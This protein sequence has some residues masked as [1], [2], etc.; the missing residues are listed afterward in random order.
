VVVFA[1]PQLSSLVAYVRV[2]QRR[3]DDGRPGAGGLKA[4][5]AGADLRLA[6]PPGTLIEDALSGEVVSDLLRPGEEAVVAR[7]G[8]GGRGNVHFK[9]SVRRSP[10]VAEPG[11]AGE[12]R[13]LRLELKLIADAGLVGA[14]NAGKS[15]LLRALSNATPKV[16]DYP[17]TT[18][19]PELG[20]VETGRG[21]RLTMADVPGLIPG[22][23]S[24]AG[25][26]L[27][28]LRHLERTRVLVL[29]LDGAAEDPFAQLESIRTEIAAYSPELAARPHLVAVNKLDLD[30]VRILR[31]SRPR[32]G[33]LWCSAHSGEGLEELVEAIVAALARAPIPDPVP[34]PRVLRLRPKRGSQEPVEVSRRGSGFALTGDRL[35]RLV[36][37]TDFNSP[38]SLQRFQVQ[39]DRIG[40]STL[41][42][43]AGAQP[44]D[45]VSACGMEFE[46]RP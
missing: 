23:A 45:M 18:L 4:G 17:F 11:R 29:L 37:V 3:A 31:S 46:Y 7:G 38:A 19:D 42:E 25:L 44:G 40:V 13:E 1:D 24:G 34:V 41:L 10:E 20:V 39:L 22:A 32:P 43:E 35:K 9:N 6:V 30:Q 12:E 15:S 8:S 33:V 21:L 28:F 5:R 16:G 2:P 27:R 14:P 36:E 26:G